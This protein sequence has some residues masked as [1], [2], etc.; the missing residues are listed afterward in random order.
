MEERHLLQH[1]LKNILQFIE[2]HPG[3]LL[4]IRQ[5]YQIAGIMRA[6][7]LFPEV[8]GIGACSLYLLVY[9]LV[10]CFNH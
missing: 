4:V 6:S 1:S 9:K 3:E 5:L 10:K 7:I 8:L 2:R